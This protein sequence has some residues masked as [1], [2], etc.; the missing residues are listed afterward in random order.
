MTAILALA[1]YLPQATPPGDGVIPTQDWIKRESSPQKVVTTIEILVMLTILSLAPAIVVMVTAFTRIV[2]VLSFLRRALATQELPPNQVVVGLSLILTFMVMT[3]TLMD[4]KRD[5]LDPYTSNDPVKMI[6]QD[7]ALKRTVTHM[8]TFMFKHVRVKDVKLFMD[9]SGETDAARKPESTL[10]EQITED[11]V[12]TMVLIPSFVISE[13]RKAFIM[14]FA[15]FLPFMI[16]DM[17]VAATLM[18][19]GMLMLPPIFISLP[20]KILLFVLVDGWH[21]VV[22]SVVESFYVSP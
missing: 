7:E 14:G 16:I 12:P 20:F 17:V 11:E 21:L 13:L 1:L 8:R 22:G 18:S 10:G 6:P 15:L 19:M 4:I 3:P 5:A 2:I 9:I